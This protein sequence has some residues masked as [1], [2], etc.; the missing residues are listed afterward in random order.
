MGPIDTGKAALAKLVARRL[1]CSFIGFPILDP[2]TFTGRG[3]LSLL[4]S[5]HLENIPEWWA[6]FYAA[7]MYEQQHRLVSELEKGPVVVTNY[8]LSYKYWM[9]NLGVDT[10][11]YITKLPHPDLGYALKGDPITGLTHL[12]FNFSSELIL[13]Q[14]R[15]YSK[16]LV[17]SIKSLDIDD[18][19]S[20]YPHVTLNALAIEITNDLKKKYKCR[21]KEK[22]LYTAD[23][24]PKKKDV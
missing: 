16:I 10:S 3:L 19:R 20:G 2:T 17:P 6:H 18:Y 5:Q 11:N 9:R 22:E 7:H 1:G 23:M 15:T 21:V 12:K 14:K 8:L 4:P 24:F 13:K